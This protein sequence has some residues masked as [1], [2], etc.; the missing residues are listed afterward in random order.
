M[1]HIIIAG[2]CGLLSLNACGSS[3]NDSKSSTNTD[4]IASVTSSSTSRGSEA[5]RQWKGALLQDIQRCGGDLS[6]YQAE[7]Q[8]LVCNSDTTAT[9]CAAQLT[10]S[11]CK[12]IPSGCDIKDLT[13]TDYAEEQCT[14]VVNAICQAYIKCNTSLTLESCKTSISSAGLDCAEVLIATINTDECISTLSTLSCA[15]DALPSVCQDVILR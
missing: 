12:A 14:S 11:S 4:V 1:K 3:S 13:D 9:S 6:G 7:V 5:C 10:S 15:T 2:L 8:G